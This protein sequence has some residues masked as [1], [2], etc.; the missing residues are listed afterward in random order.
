MVAHL[1]EV[2]LAVVVVTGVVLWLVWVVQLTVQKNL[3]QAVLVLVLLD[4]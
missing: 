3:F 4:C 2:D 1:G